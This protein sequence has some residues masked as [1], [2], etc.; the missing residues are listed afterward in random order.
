MGESLFKKNKNEYNKNIKIF[1]EILQLLE[2]DFNIKYNIK[3]IS[4]YMPI[5][6]K[7]FQF[8]VLDYKNMTLYIGLEFWNNKPY[9]CCFCIY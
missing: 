3:N 6:I 7:N 4:H 8:I 2:S 5:Q 1:N 9:I